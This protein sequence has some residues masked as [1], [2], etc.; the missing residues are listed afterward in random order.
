MSACSI[1]SAISADM[2]WRLVAEF[3]EPALHGGIGQRET[4]QS[5]ST[6]AAA[7]FATLI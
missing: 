6:F 1:F 7:S 3:E 4:S 5:A 2:R